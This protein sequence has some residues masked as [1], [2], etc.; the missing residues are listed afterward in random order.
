MEGSRCR[1]AIVIELLATKHKILL[2]AGI[3]LERFVQTIWNLI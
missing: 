1:P 3:P 2:I